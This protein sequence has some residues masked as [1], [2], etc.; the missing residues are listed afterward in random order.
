KCF[1]QAQIHIEEIGSAKIVAAAYREAYRSRESTERPIRISKQVHRSIR[2][3]MRMWQNCCP[4]AIE[5]SWSVIGVTG[6]E[7]IRVRRN[8]IPAMPTGQS[9][10]V[11][12]ANHFIQPE[13]HS[14]S[15]RPSTAK[16]EVIEKVSG[17]VVRHV[18]VRISTALAGAQR[19][20]DEAI[21]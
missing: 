1:S 16:G 4:L 19:I 12:S 7:S 14:C 17:N 20:T 9:A 13:G 15:K 5:D 21:P 10:E 6:Y 11:P 3:L 2:S 8:G 18:E